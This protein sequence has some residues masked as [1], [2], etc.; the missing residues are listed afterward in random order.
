MVGFLMFFLFSGPTTVKRF[1]A[2]GMHLTYVLATPYAASVLSDNPT[3]IRSFVH[4][5]SN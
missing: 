2:K 5:A 4:R 3:L 1:E